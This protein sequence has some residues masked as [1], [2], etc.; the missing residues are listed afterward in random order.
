M[1]STRDDFL[2]SLSNYSE[3]VKPY[4]RQIQEKYVASYYIVESDKV[5]LNAYCVKEREYALKA[6]QAYEN[7]FSGN[8]GES[9]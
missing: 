4:L 7:K 2:R 1:E 9:D 6:H 8:T 3:C 5:D